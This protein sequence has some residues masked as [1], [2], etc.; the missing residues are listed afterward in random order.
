MT[1]I[2]ADILAYIKAS[3]H[4]ASQIADVPADTPQRPIDH[5]AVIGAGL[6]GGGIAMNL[7][8]AGIPVIS[9]ETSQAA[10]DKGI[11]T[12]HKNYARQVAKG[13]LSQ[14]QM[15]EILGRLNTTLNYA[16]IA[17]A[18]IVIE[19]VFEDISVKQTVFETL[20]ATMKPGA[21]LASNTSTIDLN[22]IAAF[23][24][25]PQ[26]VIGLHFFSPA[27]IMRLLEVVRGDKTSKTV[28]ATAMH[29][30]QRMGKLAVVSGVC[31]GFIGN[32][33]IEQYSRQA[34][35]LI[36][37]G[38]TPWQVDAALENWGM[39][40][41]PFRMGDMAGLDIGWN[42]RK[43][44]AIEMPELDYPKFPD[45]ICELGRFGQKTGAGM[46]QYQPGDRTA[47]PDPNVEKM[48]AD[49]RAENGIIPRKIS[50]DEIIQRCIGALAD[51]GQEILNEGIAQRA[52]DIDM[53]YLNGYGFPKHH[54]GPMYWANKT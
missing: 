49:F 34:G 32:R 43:R 29:L 4:A 33:M 54:G 25:R 30:A 23:T 51:E 10:L 48:L 3:E 41:G 21:I 27:H 8:N 1:E 37:E 18:D 19:A 13:K 42:I 26:D 45:K 7:L 12:I 9:L 14:A 40:M 22:R 6:M 46:Y 38:A 36:E 28:L 47:Y 44:R 15:D 16:D 20:D 53:V 50:D 31:D 5:A 2:S 17:D 39:A 52:S 24:Q 35:Y 11:A